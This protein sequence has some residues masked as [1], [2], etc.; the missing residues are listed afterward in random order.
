[1]DIDRLKHGAIVIFSLYMIHKFVKIVTETRRE[2]TVA[3]DTE[4]PQQTPPCCCTCHKN[5]DGYVNLEVAE[6]M[7]VSIHSTPSFG[8]MFEK[9]FKSEQSI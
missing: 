8:H 7:S 5:N 3:P 6:T 9:L 2:D 4:E 1:M